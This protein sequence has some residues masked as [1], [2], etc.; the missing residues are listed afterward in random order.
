MVELLKEEGV[1]ESGE[2]EKESVH[3]TLPN[4]DAFV[5]GIG[6]QLPE[7]TNTL[8][9]HGWLLFVNIHDS[10]DMLCDHKPATL[11]TTNSY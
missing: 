8:L 5:C 3:V 11:S 1:D 6:N 7:K 10:I 9:W 4:V 2:E